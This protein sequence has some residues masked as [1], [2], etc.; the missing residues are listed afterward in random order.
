MAKHSPMQE[1]FARYMRRQS[2]PRFGKDYDPAIHATREEGP[3]VSRLFRVWNE[4]LGRDLHLLSRSEF[5]ATLLALF[6]PG[7]FDLHEQ[8]MLSPAPAP[9]P[10]SGHPHVATSGL[11]KHAGT[12][13]VADRLGVL[14]K[15][16]KL[17]LTN[18]DGLP[19]WVPFP[20]VGDL[21]LFLD[22][23]QSACCVN[24]SIKLTAEDFQR[25]GPLRFGRLRPQGPDAAAILRNEIEHEYYADAAIPTYRIAGNE[26]D[27]QLAANLRRIY[28]S[29]AFNPGIPPEQSEEIVRIL[30]EAVGTI[31]TIHTVMR[32]IRNLHRLEEHI[33]REILFRAIWE[34]KV[35]VELFDSLLIDRPLKSPKVDPLTRYAHWFT[36]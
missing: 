27:L 28:P 30:Q 32:H 36:S 11:P 21:L 2:R 7:L 6:H 23:D 10:L 29:H 18:A 14:K 15:H 26:I 1:R 35:R 8:K 31:S 34:R 5:H 25:R 13:K 19:E 33:V 9:H 12:V 4:Q 20:Y 16:P 17:V 24:W 22:K 3:R